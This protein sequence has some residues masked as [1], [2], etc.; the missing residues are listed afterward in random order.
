L[1]ERSSTHILAAEVERK[2]L[3]ELAQFVLTRR[4]RDVRNEL[5]KYLIARIISKHGKERE[6]IVESDMLYR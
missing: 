2:E 4:T 1:T 6:G 5:T 3:I